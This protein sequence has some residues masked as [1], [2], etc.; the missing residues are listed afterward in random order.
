LYLDSRGYHPEYMPMKKEL[1]RITAI[2]ENKPYETR[3]WCPGCQRSFWQ[4]SA[5][6][7]ITILGNPCPHCSREGL[8]M[9]TVNL[10]G[11]TNDYDHGTRKQDSGTRNYR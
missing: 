9:E 4:Y 10:K 3:W 7:G 11:G 1:R 2:L 5:N 8:Y 6:E